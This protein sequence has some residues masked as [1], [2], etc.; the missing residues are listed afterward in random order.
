MSGHT[1]HSVSAFGIASTLIG[2]IIGAGF[3]SGNEILQYFVSQGWWGLG[4]IALSCLGFYWFG[5]VSLRLGQHLRTK[6]YSHAVS[7][8]DNPWPRRYCDLMIT[9]TLFGTFVIMVAGAGGLLTN[10][11]G[12]PAVYGSVG[13]GILVVINLIWGMNGLVRIQELM[14]PAL[15]AGCVLVG[16][17]FTLDPIP[18]VDTPSE[19][20]TSPFLVHWIPN[21]ILYIAFNFQLA[22]AV[23]VPLGASTADKATLDKG[24]LGGALGLFAGSAMIFT[25]L[26]LNQ[27]AV[28]SNPYPMVELAGRIQPLLSYVYAVILVFGL[29]S[30]AVSCFYATILRVREIKPFAHLNYIWVMVMMSAVGVVLSR[31]GFSDLIGRIYPVLGF[32]GLLVMVFMVM[33]ARRKL[34]EYQR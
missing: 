14:V 25:A 29:Y 4:A 33:V 28:G 16:L 31:F 2:T 1:K 21:G 8:S 20:I 11:F 26:M 18:G 15:I 30:T 17:Y 3:A 27:G 22:I 12:L 19:I 32:G 7:P 23:L 13:I 9:V 5:R 34:P 6:E 10:L 24:A